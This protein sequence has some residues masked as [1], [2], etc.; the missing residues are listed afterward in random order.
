LGETP[1][2]L[3]TMPAIEASTNQTVE[4]EAGMER[5]RLMFKRREALNTDKQQH[6]LY[7]TMHTADFKALVLHHTAHHFHQ[8]GLI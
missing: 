4:W 5:V 7:G 6:P 8:F 2:N 1:R 3:R